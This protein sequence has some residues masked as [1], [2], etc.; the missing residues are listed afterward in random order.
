MFR[1]LFQDALGVIQYPFVW[2]SQDPDALADHVCITIH[3]M[4][5]LLI[6]LV[7]DTVA[8]NRQ[9]GFATKEIRYGIT[10]LMLASEFETQQSTISKELP[11]QSL[12]RGL[13]LSQFPGQLHQ[14]RNLIATAILSLFDHIDF[15]MRFLR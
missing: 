10:E 7:H 8:F 4:V 3:V 2:E 14:S 11:K 12:C 15:L 1:D 13:F 9:A 5:P 6:S